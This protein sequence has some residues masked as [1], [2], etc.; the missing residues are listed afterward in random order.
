M[1][2][3]TAHAERTPEI[4]PPLCLTHSHT[5]LDTLKCSTCQYKLNLSAQTP[6]TSSDFHFGVFKNP[7]VNYVDQIKE[8]A[9]SGHVLSAEK[10]E[11]QTGRNLKKETS[12]SCWV[13]IT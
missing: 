5:N 2:L 8:D 10:E 1:G 13:K 9:I 3:L 7:S 6:N 12:L 11:M 4:M